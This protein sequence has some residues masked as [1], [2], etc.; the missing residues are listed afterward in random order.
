MEVAAGMV[1]GGEVLHRG[2]IARG[3][4]EDDR[5]PRRQRRGEVN[6]LG[7]ME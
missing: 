6:S 7:A 4:G 5:A 2:G 1:I 3:E